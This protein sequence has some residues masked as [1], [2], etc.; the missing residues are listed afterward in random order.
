MQTI[1]ITRQKKNLPI[2][3]VSQTTGVLPVTLRAWERRYG[4]IK[5]LRTEK[6]HRLYSEE[7][8]ALIRQ[9]IRLINQGI[10]VG[11]V[12]QHLQDPE[13]TT[14]STSDW[15]QL[16]QQL[17]HAAQNLR[18]STIID[19]IRHAGKL[20][21]LPMLASELITPVQH[22]IDQSDHSDRWAHSQLLE[23]SVTIYLDQRSHQVNLPAAAPTIFMV[24]M[25][26]E[27]IPLSAHL[28]E[29]IA[30]EAGVDL[31]WLGR[32]PGIS[33]LT[34]IAHRHNI[35]AAVIWEDS[36]ILGPWEALLSRLKSSLEIP[37]AIGGAFA[38]QHAAKLQEISIPVLPADQQA[39]IAILK[40]WIETN[41]CP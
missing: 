25:L 4:L 34:E 35:R 3:F 5:P 23:Q 2:G 26:A 30:R 39:A 41:T 20:Y 32:V 15:P 31:R 22:F 8:I 7:D 24:T 27:K 17:L 14:A 38:L 19:L 36:E 16:R 18:K 1:D 12:R 40:G 6:G 28:F 11:K 21:P 10:A 37:V 9:I 33:A 13:G 29:S